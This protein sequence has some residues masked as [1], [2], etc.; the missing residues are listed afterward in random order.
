MT[1]STRMLCTTGLMICL[2]LPAIIFSQKNITG[3]VLSEANN[4][5]I[6]GASVYFNNTS[7]GASVNGDGRFSIRVPEMLNSELVISAVGYELMIFKV[8]AATVENKNYT[9]KL[10]GKVQQMRDVLIL[11]DALRRK[12]LSI[13]EANFL[14]ITEEASRCKIENRKDIFFTSGDAKNSFKAYSDTP[15][16]I[17]NKMLGYKISFELVDFYYNEQSGRTYY[18]GYTRFE[19]LGEKGRWIKNRRDVYRGSTLHFFRSL[20]ANKLKEEKFQIYL[21]EPVKLESA[22]ASTKPL[23]TKE[24]IVMAIGLT[25]NQIIQPDSSNISHYKV[26]VDGKLMV[27][28]D[29]APSSKR[30]LSTHTFLS[31]NMPVGFRSYIKVN[32]PFISLSNM[33]IINNP[34]DVEYSGYWIYEKVANMLPYDYEPD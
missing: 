22:A 13:F 23:A 26:K 5:P 14:G 4:L 25:A 31:G 12:Y 29:R 7:I 9:F 18:Y 2:L 28:Y 16:I 21:I 20:I 11:T 8:S 6:A 10:A 30:W 1:I 24:E 34:M 17:V 32:A 19:Q 15:L 33:G 3:V 27:Q